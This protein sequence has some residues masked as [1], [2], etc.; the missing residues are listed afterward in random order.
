[1]GG[2]FSQ[3]QPEE[4]GTL[5]ES[6]TIKPCIIAGPS[7]VGKGTLLNKVRTDF[8]EAFKVAVSHTTRAPRE[9]EEDG[10]HYFFTDREDFKA[11]VENNEFLEYADV[12]GNYYGTS[13]AS[14]NAV[15]KDG[16]ICLL[17]IDV[18]GAENVT[19]K[20]ECN[21]IFITCS[22]GFATLEQRLIGRESETE[23]SLKIRLAT[24]ATELEFLDRNPEFFGRVIVNDDL[25]E[26]AEELINQFTE[27][28]PKQMV[29]EK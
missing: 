16:C 26:A 20:T 12:H 23:A 19:S 11:R 22:S 28:Y 29:T 1:M 24:A 7:G 18:Q 6:G 15:A 14:V 5:E 17:E 25:G 8:P 4:N 10:I 3:V 13:L 2:F 9:G 21:S 27:W